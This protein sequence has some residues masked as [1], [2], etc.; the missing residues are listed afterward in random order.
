MAWT[1]NDLNA[2]KEAIATGAKRVKYADKEIEYRSLDEMLKAK[3]LI[4]DELGLNAGRKNHSY[5]TFSKGL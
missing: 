5:P 1:L 2:I 4:E 3:Q